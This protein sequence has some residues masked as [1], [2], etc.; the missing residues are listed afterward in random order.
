MSPAVGQAVATGTRTCPFFL[1]RRHETAHSTP[2]TRGSP[3][4]VTN[5]TRELRALPIFWAGKFLVFRRLPRGFPNLDEQLT[6][7]SNICCVHQPTTLE[8]V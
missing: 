3:P 1:R 4:F 5:V 2:K 6:A 7:S 8:F